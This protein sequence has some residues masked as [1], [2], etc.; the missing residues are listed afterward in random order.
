MTASVAL[1]RAY[2]ELTNE[3]S[4]GIGKYEQT[5]RFTNVNIIR[6]CVERFVDA[7]SGVSAASDELRRR[8][9]Y[10]ETTCR[11]DSKYDKAKATALKSCRLRPKK[12]TEAGLV[13]AKLRASGAVPCFL[14]DIDDQRVELDILLDGGLNLSDTSEEAFTAWRRACRDIQRD[15]DQLC[16]DGCW[17][18][19][20]LHEAGNG[21]TSG[22]AGVA[23]VLLKGRYGGSYLACMKDAAQSLMGWLQGLNPEQQSKPTRRPKAGRKAADAM[24]K[25]KEAD[26]VSNWTRARDAGRSRIE[27]VKLNKMKLRDFIRLQARVKRRESRKNK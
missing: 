2:E 14:S 19:H 10:V 5:G 12:Q 15:G 22:N 21:D 27:F 24:T 18:L 3:L 20:N 1:L 11:K 13:L 8:A 25:K 17:H 26:I 7:F 16:L 6:R 9:E 23:V 4:D